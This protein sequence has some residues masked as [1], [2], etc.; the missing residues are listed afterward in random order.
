MAFSFKFPDIGEGIHE[1]KVL[2][3][4]VTP[5]QKVREGDPLMKVETDKVVTDIPIPRTGVIKNTFGEIGQVIHVGNVI[6]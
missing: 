4:Y 1:G 3:W 2:E 6:A 5:G